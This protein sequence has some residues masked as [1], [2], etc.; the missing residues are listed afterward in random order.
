MAYD[1]DTSTIYTYKL[2]S[3]LRPAFKVD[4]WL[5]GGRRALLRV[6][7]RPQPAKCNDHNIRIRARTYVY[8]T[9]V[10]RAVV[11]V[12]THADDLMT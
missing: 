4:V 2:V 12:H 6:H 1:D 8:A 7:A 5:C 10:Y 3:G 11:H 9:Y